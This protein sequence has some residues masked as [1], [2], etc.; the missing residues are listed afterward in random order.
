MVKLIIMIKRNPELSK[1]AFRVHYEDKHADFALR[2][3]RPYLAEY[4][5][6][7][8][9][10]VFSYFDTVEGEKSGSAPVFDY[11]CITEMWFEDEAM[12]DGMFKKLAEPA[13][14]KAIAE[15]EA[16]FIDPRSVVV[17]RCEETHSKI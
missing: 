17:I 9:Q 3:I 8:P 2:Y 6:S 14:R 5:R 11:D 1:E 12:L 16:R 15:D 13:V 10:S 4:R 7:Y